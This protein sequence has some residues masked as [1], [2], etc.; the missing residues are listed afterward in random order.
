MAPLCPSIG[1]S[2][3]KSINGSYKLKLYILYIYIYIRLKI[4]Q[5]SPK[6]YKVLDSSWF[7]LIIINLKGVHRIMHVV[8]RT[9]H[10]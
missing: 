5:V 4:Y 2:L 3:V 6:M 10:S 8:Y 9:F 1:P 7:R